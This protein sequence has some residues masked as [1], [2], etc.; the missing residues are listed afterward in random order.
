MNV[1]NDP[2]RVMACVVKRETPPTWRWKLCE[3]QHGKGISESG[4]NW[5]EAVKPLHETKFQRFLCGKSVFLN[6]KF[7][8]REFH[9]H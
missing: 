6:S 2:V 9:V 1:R 5:V 4:I 8:S 3:F 7:Q